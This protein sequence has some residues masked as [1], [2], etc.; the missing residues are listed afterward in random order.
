MLSAT[1]IDY[2]IAEKTK[3]ISAGGIGI[4]HKLF[5]ESGLRNEIDSNLN[6]LKIRSPYSE[7]DHI[8]NMA[9][10]ILAGG[11]CPENLNLLRND[12]NYLN[13]LGAER[14]PAPTTAGDFCR[15]FGEKDIEKFNE[16]VNKIRTK[17]WKQ[18]PDSFF[19]EA[20]IDIDAT[21]IETLGECKEGTDFNYKLQFG[22]SALVVSFANTGEILHLSLRSGNEHS[23]VGAIEALREVVDYC[24]KAG[25]RKV[26]IR[27]DTAYSLTKE[28]D[29]WATDNHGFVVGYNAIPKILECVDGILDTDW[30]RLERKTRTR[31]DTKPRQRPKKIR[32]QVVVKREY[33]NLILEHEDIAEFAY[34]PNAC[35][36]AYRVVVIR[37]SIVEKKGQLI[38]KGSYEKYFLYMTNDWN[39]SA[40]EIVF[41]ANARCAQEKIF[42]DTKECGILYAPLGDLLSNWAY[43]SF[44]S[45]ARTLKAWIAL[46]LPE[47]GRWKKERKAEKRKVLNMTMNTFI[48]AFMLMPTQIIRSGRKIIYRILNWNPWREVFIRAWSGVLNLRC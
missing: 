3:A 16:I 13:A 31:S 44:A 35:D 7:S 30:S 5:S 32:E 21:L 26:T 36:A 4:A 22:Y 12:E 8:L 41:S 20:I 19:D 1:N 24:E 38:I 11:K 46:L 47:K 40:E 45:L 37:K 10:N 2:E 42:A 6:M 17:I 29:S 25:F 28:F 33:K 14:I 15:R 27:G 43:M 9:L 34:Q 23:N 39:S 18:Q 48:N